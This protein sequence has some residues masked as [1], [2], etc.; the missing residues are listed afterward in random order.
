MS[1]PIGVSPGPWEYRPD[2]GYGPILTENGDCVSS[3][4]SDV[5]DHD[6]YLMAA[7]PAMY[8]ALEYARQLLNAANV[9]PSRYQ[10]IDEVLKKAANE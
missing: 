10:F 8:E 7:S 3:D 2:L 4:T 6:C 9:L 5:S 1:L